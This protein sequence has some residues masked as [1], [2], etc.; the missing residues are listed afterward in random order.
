M[1]LHNKTNDM[2]KKI[3]LQSS[4]KSV[5]Y[6]LVLSHMIVVIIIAAINVPMIQILNNQVKKQ[7]NHIIASIADDIGTVFDTVLNQEKKAV[8]AIGANLGSP[9]WPNPKNGVVTDEDRYN[10]KNLNDTLKQ[11]I[12]PEDYDIQYGVY[13]YEDDL[14]IASGGILDT[15]AYYKTKLGT[16]VEKCGNWASMLKSAPGY[17]LMDS[18]FGKMLFYCVDYSNRG[19]FHEQAAAFAWIN[20]STLTDKMEEIHRTFDTDMLM[21]NSRKDITISICSRE[22]IEKLEKLRKTNRT[23]EIQSEDHEWEYV[24]YVNDMED[25]LSFWKIVLLEIICVVISIVAAF[26]YAYL[27]GSKWKGLLHSII[28]R[29]T[30]TWGI[31]KSGE[32]EIGVI[33]RGIDELA[34]KSRK[35]E[36]EERRNVNTIKRQVMLNILTGMYSENDLAL[37]ECFYEKMIGI[38]LTIAVL[39]INDIHRVMSKADGYTA[40]DIDTIFVN[41]L[42]ELIDEA[43]TGYVLTVDERVYCIIGAD[44]PDKDKLKKLFEKAKTE[45]KRY[46]GISFQVIISGS[47]KDCE[48][49][50][51]VVNN[52][53]NVMQVISIGDDIVFYDEINHGAMEDFKNIREKLKN[54]L[55]NS[56]KEEAYSLFE[57]WLTN[58]IMNG[59]TLNEACTSFI[60]CMSYVIENIDGAERYSDILD[61]VKNIMPCKSMTTFKDNVSLYFDKIVDIAVT[62]KVG[63]VDELVCKYVD[64]NY[65]DTELGV[66]GIGNALGFHSVYLSRVF[67]EKRGITILEYIT[68][69][70]MEKAKELLRETNDAVSGI[71]AATGYVSINTFNRIFKKTTGVSPSIYRKNTQEFKNEQ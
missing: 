35:R 14:I 63:G 24:I 26:L 61:P 45:I 3:K 32:N 70:R 44:N 1:K 43:Y 5:L 48:Q 36:Y 27:S 7:N 52:I 30:K 11:Y 46:F 40:K 29:L 57:C 15:K 47:V 51:G 60:L 65:R 22:Q 41:I 34:K 19:L 53:E 58:L 54:H 71:A 10:V 56:D 42:T 16:D 2:L 4:P 69:V 55:S 12:R 28:D 66:A 62:K 37:L 38:G 31:T 25:I 67:R 50:S 13:Y 21:Q 6:S 59:G 17:F 68:Y 33:E 8:Y 18:E 23:R 9:Y 64:A 39:R 49:L 20:I